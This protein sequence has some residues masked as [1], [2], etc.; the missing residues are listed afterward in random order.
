M[1]FDAEQTLEAVAATER[2]RPLPS[3]ST[4]VERAIV[5]LAV[6]AAGKKIMGK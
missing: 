4:G 6:I 5:A 3:A 2:P 1:F